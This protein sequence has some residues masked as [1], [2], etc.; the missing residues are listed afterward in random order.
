MPTLTL[1][2][3]IVIEN[4]LLASMFTLMNSLSQPFLSPIGRHPANLCH[5]RTE[6]RVQNWS[7]HQTQMEG[8]DHGWMKGMARC[9][10]NVAPN[11]RM[12]L[13]GISLPWLTQLIP[14]HPGPS[15]VIQPCSSILGHG[16]SNP[17]GAGISVRVPHLSQEN[18]QAS[19]FCLVN[20][21]PLSP[22]SV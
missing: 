11:W 9:R 1:E 19:G 21:I 17:H 10:A 15:Y 3:D 8:H 20:L 14:L 6:V 16:Q 12:A 5:S 7:Y 22:S 4:L 18:S 13:V 2:T